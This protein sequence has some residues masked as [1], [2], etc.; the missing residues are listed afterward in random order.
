[1]RDSGDEQ[2]QERR[3]LLSQEIDVWEMSS[4]EV[5]RRIDQAIDQVSNGM[6]VRMRKMMYILVD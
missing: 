5:V 1:M 2:Q 6:A 3:K 4:E